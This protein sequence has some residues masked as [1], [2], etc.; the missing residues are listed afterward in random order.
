MHNWVGWAKWNFIFI[1]FIKFAP[2]SIPQIARFCF[3]NTKFSSFWPCLRQHSPQTNM[4]MQGKKIG[5]LSVTKAITKWAAF[6]YLFLKFQ[7]IRGLWVKNF[8]NSGHLDSVTLWLWVTIFG[9]NRGFWA[10]VGGWKYRVKCVAVGV[11]H[12][13]YVSDPTLV[14]Y[15]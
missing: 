14:W 7:P 12:C 10:D 4:C 5:G 11:Y 13:L 8:Q 9:K 2:E 15:S 1:T 3:E 6:G